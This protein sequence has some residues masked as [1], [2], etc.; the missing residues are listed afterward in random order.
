M[1]SNFIISEYTKYDKNLASYFITSKSLKKDFQKKK[2]EFPEELI[3]DENTLD[4]QTDFI[5][6][7]Y[8]YYKS[9]LIIKLNEIHEKKFS[10]M[11]WT[12]A[13]NLYFLRLIMS[14]WI[15]F[16]KFKNFNPKKNKYSIINEAQ[17]YIP[18]DTP[19]S[20][21]NLLNSNFYQEQ[22]FSIYIKIFYPNIKYNYTEYNIDILKG[23]NTNTTYDFSKLKFNE[24]TILDTHIDAYEKFNI[25]DY[26]K[27][28]YLPSLDISNFSYSKEKREKLNF[29]HS[30]FKDDFD[31]FFFKSL[32]YLLPK[33][34]IEAFSYIYE[35]YNQIDFSNAKYILCENWIANDK[36]SILLAMAKEQ[37]VLH[38]ALEHGHGHYLKNN[39]ALFAHNMVDKYISYGWKDKRIKN[40]ISTGMW[41]LNPEKKYKQNKKKKDILF[42]C[43]GNTYLFDSDFLACHNLNNNA[44]ESYY[45]NMKK[46]FKNISHKIKKQILYKEYPLYLGKKRNI[47]KKFSKIFRN[48]KILD[49]NN[50]LGYGNLHYIN[51]SKLIIIGNIGTVFFE[52]LYHNAPVICFYDKDFSFIEKEYIS[53]FNRLKEVGI[54]HTSSYKM[55]IHL[56]K[57]AANPYNWWNNKKVTEARKDFLNIFSSSH[58]NFYSF[59]KDLK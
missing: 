49:N 15:R 36:L 21:L 9:H 31:K 7:K 26:A 39:Y 41:R 51:S 29:S 47:S 22:I 46:L 52:T 13:L 11:F 32:K 44:Q 55:A 6:E 57:I 56:N 2:Y 17:Y 8:E 28:F 58:N 30:L 33:S 50:E 3:K 14:Q 20:L 23:L 5:L 48:C 53:I 16:N 18:I 12:K 25:S 27:Y 1:K 54:L 37:G 59:L 42:V 38:Y 4:E 43:Y 45:Q 35:A 40:L 34:Y 24:I 19:N 10:D